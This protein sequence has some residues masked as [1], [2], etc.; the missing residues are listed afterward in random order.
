MDKAPSKP[1]ETREILE[2]VSAN[3]VFYSQW[4]L[5]DPSKQWKACGIACLAM[6]LNSNLDPIALKTGKVRSVFG[7][8]D[9]L[10]NL[11][12]DGQVLDEDGGYWEG[13]G[14]KHDAILETAAAYGL[15]SEAFYLEDH[16]IEKP[17]A[18]EQIR[19]LLG[20]GDQFIAS[21]RLPSG[22]GHLLVIQK[23]DEHGVTVLDPKEKTLADGQ[24]TMSNEDFMNQWSGTYLRFWPEHGDKIAQD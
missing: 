2:D 8:L 6:V 15:N 21:V 4:E 3:P 24:I 22:S 7:S 9:T 16:D 12:K 11:T 17:E 23:I 1:E 13:V 18:L 5:E 14:W 20:Q 10:Y 19:T